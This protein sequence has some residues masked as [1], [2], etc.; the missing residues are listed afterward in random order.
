MFELLNSLFKM[1]EFI[2]CR[3]FAF[4]IRRSSF[5]KIKFNFFFIVGLKKGFNSKGCVFLQKLYPFWNPFS[6]FTQLKQFVREFGPI[7]FRCQFLFHCIVFCNYISLDKELFCTSYKLTAP[8]SNKIVKNLSVWFNFLF[9][10]FFSDSG[11]D[12]FWNLRKV[13]HAFIANIIAICLFI[14]NLF[15]I[16]I[17]RSLVP[18]FDLLRSQRSLA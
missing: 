11:H 6:F 12:I 1:K 17:T 7:I 2:T 8:T 15:H 13:N 5:W 3:G 14:E 16:A 18:F 4:F 10:V 9:I